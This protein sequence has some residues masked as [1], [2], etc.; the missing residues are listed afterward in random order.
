[1]LISSSKTLT[2]ILRIMFEQITRH[3]VARSSWHII[4]HYSA[5]IKPHPKPQLLSWAPHFR[6]HA[7]E[8]LTTT[9]SEEEL[10]AGNSVLNWSHD[11]SQVTSFDVWRLVSWRKEEGILSL[12]GTAQTRGW[13]ANLTDRTEIC[14]GNWWGLPS[15]RVSTEVRYD[16]ELEVSCSVLLSCWFSDLMYGIS[17]S[18]VSSSPLWK[19]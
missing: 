3:P 8:E 5:F 12:E 19:S 14:L 16:Q 1:M 2:E 9:V 15:G 7:G 17:F 6:N 11:Q 4:N 13:K 18:E 10:R